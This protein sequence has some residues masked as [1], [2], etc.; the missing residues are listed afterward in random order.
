MREKT[1]LCLTSQ[2]ALSRPA[3]PLPENR[4][5]PCLSAVPTSSFF[6]SRVELV[7]VRIEFEELRLRAGGSESLSH[8]LAAQLLWD[9]KLDCANAIALVDRIGDLTGTHFFIKRPLGEDGDRD[10][11]CSSNPCLQDRTLW[12]PYRPKDT[13]WA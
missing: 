5:E 10:P 4:Q 6:D 3:S 7:A 1:E 13:S 2:F 12:L 8:F 9:A 11:V